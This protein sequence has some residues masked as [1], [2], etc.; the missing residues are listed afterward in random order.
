MVPI[1]YFI[2]LSVVCVAIIGVFFAVYSSKHK[3]LSSE[4]VQ[5]R[6]ELQNLGHQLE[7]ARRNEEALNK[8]VLYLSCKIKVEEI[9]QKLEELQTKA[10]KAK[11]GNRWRGV[12]K[13]AFRVL[14][15]GSGFGLP[16]GELL[17]DIPLPSPDIGGLLNGVDIDGLSPEDYDF[18]ELS[19]I[20]E[21]PPELGDQALAAI[22]LENLAGYE[23]QLDQT[24]QELNK[25]LA[26]FD[27]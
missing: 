20:F 24:L 22:D 18:E 14:S 9:K 4:L 26:S 3:R 12:A 27:N 7:T 8:K 17:P 13:T 25:A 1:I 2:L 11:R 19:G 21:G 15:I 16:G 5:A 6:E 10:R 23:A